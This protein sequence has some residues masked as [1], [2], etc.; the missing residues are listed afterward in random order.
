MLKVF[1]ALLLWKGH[2]SVCRMKNAYIDISIFCRIYKQLL[3]QWSKNGA[4][5]WRS[6]GALCSYL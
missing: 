5:R 6:F 3:H 2:F 4:V 1:C